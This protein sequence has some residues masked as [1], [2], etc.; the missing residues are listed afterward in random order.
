MT[1]LIVLDTLA[2]D[3]T[4]NFVRLNVVCLFDVVLSSTNVILKSYIHMFKRRYKRNVRFC[5]GVCMC[6]ASDGISRQ[7]Q[8]T[9]DTIIK[10]RSDVLLISRE[11]HV[12]LLVTCDTQS[13]YCA[14]VC[15]RKQVSSATLFIGRVFAA[16][17]HI[18][19]A[20]FRYDLV[21]ARNSFSLSFTQSGS[22]RLSLNNSNYCERSDWCCD[23]TTVQ[24]TSK[25]V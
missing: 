20:Y 3:R 7:R 19:V 6:F 10:L 22:A 12:R 16:R 15:T 17:I 25:A 23:P 9:H 8:P 21:Y 5:A 1:S 2:L 18:R 4:C 11:L 13:S 14:N 24:H